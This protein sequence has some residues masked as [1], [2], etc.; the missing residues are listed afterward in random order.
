MSRQLERE[1]L[2]PI[3]TGCFVVGCGAGDRVGSARHGLCA[4][5]RRVEW[6][7]FESATPEPMEQHCELPRNGDD[8]LLL[9]GLVAG[10]RRYAQSETTQIRV[11]AESPEDVVCALD[12]QASQRL[13]ARLADRELRVAVTGRLGAWCQTEIGTDLA[14]VLESRR[15]FDRQHEGRCGDRSHSG[16]L[17]QKGDFGISITRDLVEALLEFVDA[18]GE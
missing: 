15:I 14:A 1:A 5:V 4:T 18:L 10:I 2:R 3:P 12:Q 6:L 7:V 11:R 9:R 13:V 16:D 17:L 8:R